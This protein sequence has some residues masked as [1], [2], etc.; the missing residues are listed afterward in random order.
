MRFDVPLQSATVIQRPNRFGLHADLAG[1]WVYAHVP[2]SGRLTELI[3]P[4]ARVMLRP[5][6]RPGRR[7]THD[8]VLAREGRFWVCI[9]SRL[10]PDLLLEYLPDNPDV[11]GRLHDIRREPA[12]AQGRFDLLLDTTRGRWLVE[13]KSV[14]L[15][16]KGI[17]LFPDAPTQRGARHLQELAELARNGSPA[18]VVFVAQRNDVTAV[19]PNAATDQLFARNLQQAKAGGVRIVALA[20]TVSPRGVRAYRQ[21]PVVLNGKTPGTSN[22]NINRK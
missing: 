18:A 19:A 3:Y 12:S 20:C 9:D 22:R 13:T 10:P 17:G 16:R 4:G 21:V 11:F 7:T 2:T 1:Q 15:A 6:S 14:T 8:A 5:A